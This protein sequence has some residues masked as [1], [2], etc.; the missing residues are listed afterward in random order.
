MIIFVDIVHLL[1]GDIVHVV[2]HGD[3]HAPGPR[4][5]LYRMSMLRDINGMFFMACHKP[6][7]RVE[8]ISLERKRAAGNDDGWA[9]MATGLNPG[10]FPVIDVP[11][12]E[13]RRWCRRHSSSISAADV[14]ARNAIVCCLCC[15]MLSRGNRAGDVTIGIFISG[16]DLFCRS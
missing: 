15:C 12:A 6:V 13:R 3:R 9:G 11:G 1:G 8:K 14:L 5:T 16:I 10:C 2:Q 7:D 4:T